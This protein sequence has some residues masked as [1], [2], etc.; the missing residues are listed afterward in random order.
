MPR[1][2]TLAEFQAYKGAHGP[3]IW[4]E[5]GEHWMCPSC[6]RSKF[7]ILRWTTRF[8][9]SPK[10]FSDWMAVLHRHH[11]HS[12]DAWREAPRFEQTIICDQCNAADGTAK[13]ELDLPEKFSFSP[14]EISRF[15][16]SFPHDKHKINLQAAKSI[17]EAVS[18][19]H[20]RFP[21]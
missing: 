15:V 13:R 20:L 11:D 14:L 8:P 1:I 6:C 21:T 16:V 5:V 18:Q 9:R 17:Y 7:Q 19:S 3:H 4:T 2:P 10:K 12:V